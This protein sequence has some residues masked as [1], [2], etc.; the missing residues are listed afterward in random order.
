MNGYFID[1]PLLDISNFRG[2]F[3]DRSIFSQI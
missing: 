2:I 3:Y 1:N